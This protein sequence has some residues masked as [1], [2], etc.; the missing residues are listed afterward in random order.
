MIRTER[1]INRTRRELVSVKEFWSRLAE[2]FPVRLVYYPGCG[3]NASRADKLL[4]EALGE[5]EIV[6]LD[7]D[8]SSIIRRSY[9][10]AEYQRPPFRDRVFDVLFI[11]DLHADEPERMQSILRTVRNGGL[12]IYSTYS[13]GDRGDWRLLLQDERLRRVS[14]IRSIIYFRKRPIS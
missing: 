4:T 10:R 7:E 5:E 6:R 2:H 12:I 13:C 11:Q 14:P 9:V 1:E 3:S 8:P